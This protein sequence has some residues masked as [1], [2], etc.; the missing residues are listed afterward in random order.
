MCIYV[1]ICVWLVFIRSY[2]TT[3]VLGRTR[4]IKP[5]K[6]RPLH[7]P[8]VSLLA[9]ASAAIGTFGA[10]L[11][12][13]GGVALAVGVVDCLA[14]RFWWGSANQTLLAI[15]AFGLIGGV[16]PA[17]WY[18]GCGLCESLHEQQWQQYGFRDSAGTSS[19]T[20]TEEESV[21]GSSYSNTNSSAGRSWSGY[22]SPLSSA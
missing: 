8:A 22:D 15:W 17:C 4:F 20:D 21:A 5:L 13:W 3:C 7:M 14:T 2:A 12:N 18:Y 1:Y 10:R 16:L 19:E 6:Q 9:S 11:A